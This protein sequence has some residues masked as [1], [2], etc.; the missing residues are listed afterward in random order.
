MPSATL[1][2]Q[3]K[4][5]RNLLAENGSSLEGT[6]VC[7][8]DILVHGETEEIHDRRLEQVLKVTAAASLKLN[9]AKFK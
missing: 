9:R 8:D 7:T 3:N 5:V 6:E 2:L 1:I 4:R